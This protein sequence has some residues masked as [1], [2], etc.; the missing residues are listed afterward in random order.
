MP[1][2]T[3]ARLCLIAI[4]A[5]LTVIAYRTNPP[6]VVLAADAEQYL[7]TD[8]NW[9]IDKN[10]TDQLNNMRAKGWKLMHVGWALDDRL[11]W[12]K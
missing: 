8:K 9:Q 2:D 6:S 5:L 4:V 7:V 1:K 11:V 10:A 12:Y 3:L